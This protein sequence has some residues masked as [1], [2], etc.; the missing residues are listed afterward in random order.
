VLKE[1]VDPA[2]VGA[3][4]TV[5][6]CGSYEH[7]GTCRWPHNNDVD[8]RAAPAVFRTLFVAEAADEEEVRRRIERALQEASE[9][10]VRSTG[11]RPL[12]PAEEA[13]AARLLT[14]PL[15]A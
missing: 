12:R 3:A 5:A 11:A 10:E 1:G 8:T 14:K 13:L 15:P 6:L 9:W 7:E 2:A 4:V